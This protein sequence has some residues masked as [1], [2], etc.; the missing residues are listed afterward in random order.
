MIINKLSSFIHSG[1]Y[2]MTTYVKMTCDKLY[3]CM[4]GARSMDTAMAVSRQRCSYSICK[5]SATAYLLSQQKF[6]DVIKCKL[7][8]SVVASFLV[9]VVVVNIFIV[10]SEETENITI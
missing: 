5:V 6:F 8:N 1:C 4:H 2:E 3:A 7:H 10:R 9:V